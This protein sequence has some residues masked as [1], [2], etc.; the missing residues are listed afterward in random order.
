M[1]G[2]GFR[3]PR[4]KQELWKSYPSEEAR[5]RWGILLLESKPGEPVS[6][7]EAGPQL[8]PAATQSQALEKQTCT[9]GTPMYFRKRCRS[10]IFL[11]SERWKRPLV[12]PSQLL[13]CCQA[14]QQ[15]AR[16]RFWHCYD[17]HG[18]TPTGSPITA[19]H[20]LPSPH[21]HLSLPCPHSQALGKSSI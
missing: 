17:A 1:V 8:L 15:K 19:M 2:R 16:R 11:C 18:P 4:H 20:Y 10:H 9:F 14:G 21:W 5:N 3:S 13:S 12:H 6:P 7:V